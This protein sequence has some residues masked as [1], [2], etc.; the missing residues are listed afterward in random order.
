MNVM[1]K[2]MVRVV[3][4]D[5]ESPEQYKRLDIAMRAKGFSQALVGKKAAY[6]LPCGEYWYRGDTSA[7]DV[8]MVAAAAAERT[9]QGFGIIVVKV[10][11]WSVMGLKKSAASASE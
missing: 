2:F 5:A 4:H 1:P 8:R 3:L 11:G 6:Q 10:D 7:S 9:G